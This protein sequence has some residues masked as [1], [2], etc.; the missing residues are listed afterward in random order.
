MRYAGD[1]ARRYAAVADACAAIISFFYD[2]DALIICWLR[3][4][5]H[6][7]DIFTPPPDAPL[8]RG[9]VTTSNTSSLHTTANNMHQQHTSTPAAEAF[10]LLIFLHA[11]AS[12]PL[13]AVISC[14]TSLP[15][16][17]HDACFMPPFFRRYC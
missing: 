14:H 6:I 11:A 7:D 4:H 3:R 16:Y 15:H 2:A 10:R 17:F 5:C 12:L 13:A 8:R 9:D 1:Y